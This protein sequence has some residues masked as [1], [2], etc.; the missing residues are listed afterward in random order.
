[1][2]APLDQR[3]VLACDA[4]KS[5]LLP[6][7][8]LRGPDAVM[9][10]EGFCT[11]L[12]ILAADTALQPFPSVTV[13]EKLPGVCVWIFCVLAPFDHNQDEA[14]EAERLSVSP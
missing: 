4:F 8:K 11:I 5:T 1:M 2:V 14:F 6:E 3:Y 12:T 9:V 13:T 7:Q 10:G